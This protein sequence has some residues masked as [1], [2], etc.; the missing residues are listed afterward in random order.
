M[1]NLNSLLSAVNS[2]ERS[3]FNE[4]AI[5]VFNYQAENNPTFKSYLKG[6]GH[7][8]HAESIADLAYLP[9][10]LFKNHTIKTGEWKEETVFESSGTT[11]S[12][13]SRHFVSNLEQYR[14]STQ[15]A[16]EKQYGSLSEFTIL[17]LLP[18]YI[19]RGNS[20]LIAMVDHFISC[21]N[22]PDSGYYLNDFKAL[23]DKL[24]LLKRNGEKTIL[25]GVTFGLLDFIEEF[26]LEYHELVIMETGGMKG[27]RKEMVRSEVHD[28]LK[29]SFGVDQIHSEYGMTELN[30]QAYSKGAGVFEPAETMKVIARDINDPFE[31]MP[32][33]KT[34]AL[35][36][37]DLQNLNT[38]A[39]IETKDLGRVYDD[40]SFEV[41]GRMDNSDVRGCNLMVL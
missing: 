5:V 38:C 39:F 33:G 29:R 34:G 3:S 28:L 20:G 13:T 32:F 9:I 40:G 41:M 31:L 25:W 1:A 12:Q 36:I 22:S 14:Q 18:S 24:L 30:S 7:S 37:I 19:E 11:G 27:R 35:N 21:T 16:F 23:C 8:C 17:A 26:E 10:E 4:L 15:K 6:I 2:V